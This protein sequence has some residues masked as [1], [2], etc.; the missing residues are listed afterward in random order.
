MK[1]AV[2]GAGYWAAFQVAAWQALN[3]E[4][5][6]VW[7]RTKSKALD[8]AQKFNIPKVFD[9]PEQIFEWG[10]FDIADIIADV[11]AHEP[12]VMLAVAHRKA[13]IC[14]KP[15]SGTYES[16]KRMVKV[17]SDA[18]VW[19][20]IHE[21]FRYQPS[22]IAFKK[23]LAS[24]VMG[25]L[26]RANIAMRS[27]DRAILSVQPALTVMPHMVLRDMGPH[28]FDVA[29]ALFGEMH[30]IFAMPINTYP[31]YYVPDAAYC[32]LRT[33]SGMALHCDLVHNW[34][35][36]IYVEG[37][38]GSI[39]LTLDN[40]IKIV[41]G[42]KMEFID[43]KNWPILDY[44]PKED[45]DIHGGHVFNSIP[46]CLIDLRDSFL[47]GKPAPTSGEDNLKTMEL[48][49]AAIESFDTEKNIVLDERVWG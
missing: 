25:K 27:P 44:I 14:Q 18:G 11:D 30:S 43:T 3:V 17:C 37:E 15:M 29:R 1:V 28:I 7:N 2:F 39:T 35:D 13:V 4:V 48:V 24:G 8:F 42:D 45:W 19:Y 32:T 10:Q 33:V 20:A 21:N 22:I 46:N 41:A 36:R 47:S 34:N 5:V 38:L 26:T 12:L 40:V 6:A 9:T 31:E 49:F 23:V 16:C